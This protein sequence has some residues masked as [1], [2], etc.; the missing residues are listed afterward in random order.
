[1]QKQLASSMTATAMPERS[2]RSTG[3][4]KIGSLDAEFAVR[5]NQFVW[6]KYL[7]L[8]NGVDNAHREREE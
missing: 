8:C 4:D 6:A 5:L 3:I 1:M 2:G 7:E